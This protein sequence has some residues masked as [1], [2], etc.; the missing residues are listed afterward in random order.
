MKLKTTL[1]SFFL[2]LITLLIAGRFLFF[3]SYI[4]TQKTAFRSELIQHSFKEARTIEVS[5][6]DLFQDKNGLVWKENNKE[7]LIDGVYH[8]VICIKQMGNNVL[9]SLLEDKEENRLFFSFF[10]SDK[11]KTGFVTD[12]IKILCQLIFL[13]QAPIKL[14]EIVSYFKTLSVFHQLILCDFHSEIIKPPK[15]FFI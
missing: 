13:D 9:V 2:I 4:A 6:T 11:S 10:S 7:L 12:F 3:I 14:T 15:P 8:E 1:F 5:A